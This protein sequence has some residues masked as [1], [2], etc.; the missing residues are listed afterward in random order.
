V[1]LP[2]C[3]LA[4]PI[5]AISGMNLV[6]TRSV[7]TK[8]MF[9][10]VFQCEKEYVCNAGRSG[11]HSGNAYCHS[12][13]SN[14]SPRLVRLVVFRNAKGNVYKFIYIFL[15]SFCLCVSLRLLP[16]GGRNIRMLKF[17]K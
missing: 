2:T 4:S 13:R 6:S 12:V 17:T 15:V 14:S 16:Y 1:T 9:C 5:I 10:Q 11:L 7:F 8:C 3:R